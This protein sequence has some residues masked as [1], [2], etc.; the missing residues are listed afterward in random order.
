MILLTTPPGGLDGQRAA[1][2]IPEPAREALQR[3]LEAWLREIR[4][5]NPEAVPDP[6]RDGL[7]AFLEPGETEVSLPGDG[8]PQPL[9]EM[10]FE[11]V[12][13]DA[14]A[15]A[16]FCHFVPSNS[17][18]LTLCVP[19][20]PGLDASVRAYLV[21]QIEPSA[22]PPARPAERARGAV[23]EQVPAKESAR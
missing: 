8:W 4:R 3:R 11:A 22:R 16:F 6:D 17:W 14:Q 7:F 15:G 2:A 1:A 9:A 20:G 19:D 12:Q 23:R 13:F 5:H 10:P 18:V 21:E